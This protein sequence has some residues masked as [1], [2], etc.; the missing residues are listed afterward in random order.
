[1]NWNDESRANG[2]YMLRAM[3]FDWTVPPCVLTDS[4][5]LAWCLLINCTK[6]YTP[7]HS[8]RPVFHWI[9]QHQV[10]VVGASQATAADKTTSDLLLIIYDFCSPCWPCIRTYCLDLSVSYLWISSLPCLSRFSNFVFCFATSSIRFFGIFVEWSMATSLPCEPGYRWEHQHFQLQLCWILKDPQ[11]H[12]ARLRPSVE[13]MAQKTPAAFWMEDNLRP[14]PSQ[15][16]R[17]IIKLLIIEGPNLSLQQVS[18][19]ARSNLWP[20][21]WQKC[22]TL[23]LNHGFKQWKTSIR[24]V[25]GVSNSRHPRRRTMGTRLPNSPGLLMKYMNFYGVLH[26]DCFTWPWKLPRHWIFASHQQLSVS[27]V[28]WHCKAQGFRRDAMATHRAVGLRLEGQPE[29]YKEK[30]IRTYNLH[31]AKKCK[32][33]SATLGRPSA[34]SLVYSLDTQRTSKT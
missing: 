4:P 33:I 27:T 29:I 22:R 11:Q 31:L 2:I 24:H 19:V 20:E 5:Q 12:S 1:M 14:P 10:I 25:T 17:S 7:F 21:R 16:S 23:A 26:Q 34:N 15:Y 30:L 28:Q 6:T 3:V 8:T 9:Q 13:R 18:Q 32:K